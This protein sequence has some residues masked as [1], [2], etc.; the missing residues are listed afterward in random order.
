[1]RKPVHFQETVIHKETYLETY[2]WE[3]KKS[4]N[5]GYI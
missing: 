4:G 5:F 1:M 2:I 3:R